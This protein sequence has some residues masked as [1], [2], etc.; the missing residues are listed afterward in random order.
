MVRWH[1]PDYPRTTCLLFLLLGSLSYIG[2]AIPL[3]PSTVE[4]DTGLVLPPQGLY[5]S[6]WIQQEECVSHLDALA[7]RGFELILNYGQLYGNSAAQIAY[8]DRAHALGM[9]IIWSI[10]YRPDWTA[11]NLL[12]KYADLAAECKCSDNL[13][14]ISYFVN[15]V[16]DHPATWGYYLADEVSPEEHDRLLVY[17]DLISSSIPT[18]PGCTLWRVPTIRWNCISIFLLFCRIPPTSWG[19]VITRMGILTKETC[20]PATP[21]RRRASPRTGRTDWGCNPQSCSRLFR[22]PAM[23]RSLCACPGQAA[24]LSPATPR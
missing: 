15:L 23:L 13:G 11:D 17:S 19:R 14:L 10:N 16:K 9:K 21:G 20:R 22:K 1:R 12:A 2:L 24:R 18:T 7:A 3:P 5:D 4:P 8:A 6:C